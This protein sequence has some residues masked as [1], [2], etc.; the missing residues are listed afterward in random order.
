MKRLLKSIS[1]SIFLSAILMIVI[2]FTPEPVKRSPFKASKPWLKAV[3]KE[4]R[5]EVKEPSDWFMM[6]KT[7]PGSELNLSAFEEAVQQASVLRENRGE[8]DEA[9]TFA[10]PTNIG[11]RITA[12]AVHPDNPD[13]IYAGAALGGVFKSTDGGEEFSP[14]FE[15]DFN[16]SIGA[17]AMDP[18]DSSRIWVG[19][20][21][22]NSSGDSYPGQGI[23]LTEDEGENWT[24]M[25]LDSVAHIG[26]IVID[27]SDPD[28]IWVAAM[29]LL[30]GTNPQRGVYVTDDGGENWERSLFLNDSTGCIDISFDPQRPDTLFAAMWERVRHPD[31]RRSGGVNS[32]VWRTYDGGE[33]WEHLTNGLPQGNTVGRIGIALAPSNPDRVYA[34][35][36][37]HPGYLVDLFRSD[38][39][40]DTWI[41][42]NF[43]RNYAQ[44]LCS[45]FGWY[46]GQIM[47]DPL[48]HNVVFVLGV[49][50]FRSLDGGENWSA[51]F[52]DAHVDHHALWI[53][54][55]DTDHIISGH[56][57]GV[58]VSFDRGRFSSRFDILPVTQFY[59]ITA[60]PSEPHRL[61]GGTQ[62]NSTMRTMDGE[63]D[64]YE[65]IL[66]GDGFYS[67]VH[68]E[69]NNIIL[70][71]AQWGHIYLSTNGGNEFFGI[72]GEYGDDR[73]NWMTPFLLSPHDPDLLYVGT[74]R[75]WR[76]DLDD[77]FDWEILSGDLTD[78]GG[79]FGLTFG[80]ITTL[81][82]APSDEDVIYAG[83]D[84]G[85]VWVTTSD[86]DEWNNISDDLPVR[87]VTRVAPHPDS[88]SVVYVALS[89]YRET[90]PLVHL[91]RGDNYGE[92]WTDVSGNM[93]EAPVNDII[94]DPLD[95]SNLYAGTDFGVYYSTNYGSSWS[96]LGEGLPTSS[97]Y[98]LHLIDSTRILAAGTHGRSIWTYFIDVEV[99]EPPERFHLVEPVDSAVVPFEEPYELTLTWNNAIDPDTADTV[100][101]T[102]YFECVEDDS[103][104]KVEF[105]THSDTLITV[106]P[107]TE[108]IR[109]DSL[110]DTLA[111]TWWVMAV[112]GEDTVESIERWS[113]F[114]APNIS[115][116]HEGVNSQI[117]GTFAITSV[118]PNPFNSE[119]KITITVPYNSRIQAE[120]FDVLGRS[121]EQ[122]DLGKVVMGFHTFTW[123]PQAASGVY[124]LKVYSTDGKAVLKK[125]M[126]IR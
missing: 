59:A 25:G 42:L 115:G 77:I 78:G 2:L 81:A 8:L 40:G 124:F 112:S 68:P 27:P 88:A 26:K 108:I 28:R 38:N 102:I 101:Y 82:I 58:N 43:P 113:F 33:N 75:V 54:P 52:S 53:N 44:F 55:N 111:V 9:W 120:I 76:V 65:I 47:V 62:D 91:W 121:V 84:D 56:D 105:E 4:I 45:S 70:A 96:T 60:D 22:A 34:Y 21:E 73:L 97:V 110:A 118:Y 17:L 61:Y 13:T 48:N 10:G 64:S 66:G 119:V 50:M 19:T 117:P 90:D 79:N 100:S 29:G 93:P 104:D 49:R 41:A 11:G 1:F 23:Y 37:N 94:V 69:D 80:T 126:Y 92:L 35:I 16:L 5:G 103:T 98:D 18:T 87:W 51:V 39:G 32:G 72:W 31:Q 24:Y 83:T 95:P 3:K 125:L 99:N 6:Q 109:S 12:L 107:W 20:G 74:Y 114:L 89:G 106:S 30:F 85:N 63:I 15:E 36:A 71:S 67:Q 57:G 122:L 123:N 116:L 46:F 14:V 86:G 7:W